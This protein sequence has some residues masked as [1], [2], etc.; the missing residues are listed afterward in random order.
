M[1][2][3]LT[4]LAVSRPITVL[5]DVYPSR[6]WR[7]RNW[8]ALTACALLSRAVVFHE[9]HELPT[10]AA[11]PRRGR[12][13]RI[14]LA[15]EAMSLPREVP[16]AR[17]LG[18]SR[19]RRGAR[20]G[21]WIHPRKNCERAVEALS[22]LPGDAQLWLIGSATSDAHAY[23]D[24][25][26]QLAAELGVADRLRITGYV[27]DDELRCRLAADRCG[28]R[29]LHSYFGSASALDS[30]RGP[31]SGAR[32]RPGGDARAP[33]ARPGRASGSPTIRRR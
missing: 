14:P 28:P 23:R 20:D 16:R 30:P 1:Q 13:F 3:V 4:L 2:L 25:L 8:W 18:V 26:E 5:H 32:L 11:V 22:R 33:R 15:V 31:P 27:G 9:Q 19:V 17:E 24:R 6:R 7:S 21:G 29:A 12:L 10:L